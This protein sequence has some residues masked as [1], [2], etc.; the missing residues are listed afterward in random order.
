[1][2]ARVWCFQYWTRE[3]CEA[4]RDDDNIDDPAFW[5]GLRPA[6]VTHSPTIEWCTRVLEAA[7]RSMLDDRD[8]EELPHWRYLG[9]DG[10]DFCWIIDD[11]A[12]ARIYPMAVD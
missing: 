4:E 2:N 5:T 9:R 6:A 7:R 8:E 11:H 3:G 12:H 10:E 1:M